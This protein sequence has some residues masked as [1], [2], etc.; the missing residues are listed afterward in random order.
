MSEHNTIICPVTHK[1]PQVVY[2]GDNGNLWSLALAEWP[3]HL[4]P[5]V[6]P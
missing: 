3:K 1:P 5:E 2:L 6:H 4:I